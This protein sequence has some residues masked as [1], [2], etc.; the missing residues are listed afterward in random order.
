MPVK[1]YY[2]EHYSGIGIRPRPAGVGILSNADDL[3]KP[4]PGG[5][6]RRSKRRP[7]SKPRPKSKRR[8]KR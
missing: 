7:P 4:M 6:P 1:A 5:D 3:L 2:P 8:G